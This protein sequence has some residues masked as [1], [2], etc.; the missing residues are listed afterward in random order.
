V[1]IGLILLIVLLLAFAMSAAS[2]AK[3]A[4]QMA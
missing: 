3:G 4:T 1:V 2:R